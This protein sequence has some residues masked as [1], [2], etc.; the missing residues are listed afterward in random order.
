MG[1]LIGHIGD[2]TIV[3]NG[4]PVAGSIAGG[5][6]QR[7]IH[8]RRRRGKVDAVALLAL[9]QEIQGKVKIGGLPGDVQ[10]IGADAADK[11]RHPGNGLRGGHIGVISIAHR[12]IVELLLDPIGELE[13]VILHILVVVSVHMAGLLGDV[14]RSHTGPIIDHIVVFTDFNTEIA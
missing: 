12:Q 8:H 5:N 1:V 13:A 4:D 9:L 2:H 3:C 10:L 6:S 14:Q 7:A 11:L